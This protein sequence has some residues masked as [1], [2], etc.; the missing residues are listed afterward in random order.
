MKIVAVDGQGG[1]LGRA[2]IKALR[3]RFGQL[4]ITAVGTN[5]AATENMLKA[6]ASRGA[7]GENAV[8]VAC[9]TADVIIGPL[10]IVIA[11]SLLGE[12]TPVMA[13]AI[14]SSRARKILLPTARC[15]VYVAGAG[16]LSVPDAVGDAVR[17]LEGIMQE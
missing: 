4:D 6:G 12:I 13:A 17:L 7:T 16:E 14:G 15:G 8:V 11:D 10:G 1:G 5:S 9:R 3:E 2:V